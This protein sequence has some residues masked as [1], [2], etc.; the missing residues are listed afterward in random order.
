MGIV[1]QIRT[2][3]GL[4]ADTPDSAALTQALGD[5][6]GRINKTDDAIAALQAELPGAVIRSIDAGA[7]ER[8]KL[9]TLRSEREGLVSAAEATRSEIAKA[10]AREA[11]AGRQARWAAVVESTGAVLVDISEVETSIETLDDRL[12]KLLETILTF[13]AQLPWD[14]PTRRSS[15]GRDLER[16]SRLADTLRTSLRQARELRLNAESAK[17]SAALQARDTSGEEAA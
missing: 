15:I 6:N 7:T 16:M 1:E 9:A 10:L 2:K 17:A 3:F 11:L 14:V 8:R 4:S 5:L 12:E 13:E